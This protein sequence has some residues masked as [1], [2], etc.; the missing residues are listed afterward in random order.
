MEIKTATI[1]SKYY[2]ESAK[3]V[4]EMFTAIEK[5]CEDNSDQ[6]LCVLIDEVESIANSRE[7]SMRGEAQDSLRATNALLTGLDRVRKY[8]N[9]II[10]C[11]SNILE[12]LDS[13]FLDRCSFKRLVNVPAVAVKYEILRSNIQAMVDD[14]TI[15]GSANVLP[16]CM[17]H[18]LA[19]I[20]NHRITTCDEI[21][22]VANLSLQIEMQAYKHW[23]S[24]SYYLDVNSYT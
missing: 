12:C 6:F 8:C 21:D 19:A 10:L 1:L 23:I 17:C 18:T 13:A 15:S 9:L 20:G 5:M 4:D 3:R 7:S 2:S 11:T 24:T 22:I 16:S 14:G